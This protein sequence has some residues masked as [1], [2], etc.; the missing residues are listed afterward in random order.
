MSAEDFRTMAGKLQGRTSFLYFHLMGEPLLHPQLGEFLQIA[1]ELGFRVILTTNGT[2]LEQRRTELLAAP[3]LHRVNISL[4]SYEAN[5]EKVAIED[6]VNSCADFAVALAETGKLCSLRLW[7]GGG[8][9]ARNGEI[10]AIL[11]K[12]FS[13]PWIRGSQNLTLR[14]R[15]FLEYGDLFDWP[16][17]TAEDY[18]EHCFC[19]GL[20]DH[21]GV[22][23][24]GTVV[25]CCLDHNGDAA[26]GNL[27]AEELEDIL[28]SPR[29]QAIY[30]GFSGRKAV[31]PLCRRCGYARRFG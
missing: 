21:I 5:T 8:A 22:L 4:Q 14:E 11:E 12:R 19:H 29:A 1:G 31:E 7:N 15:I 13:K 17:L 2:L 25:P 26:L 30:A 16:D 24:D 10:E 6:Y 3:A 28:A 27:R 20:R 18:G 23:C 9:E